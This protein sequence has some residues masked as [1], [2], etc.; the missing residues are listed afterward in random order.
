MFMDQNFYRNSLMT[1]N[2]PYVEKNFDIFQIIDTV[3]IK[4]RN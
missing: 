4:K 2:W 1:T 3:Q